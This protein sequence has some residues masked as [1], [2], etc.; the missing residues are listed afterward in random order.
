MTRFQ[1]TRRFLTTRV[2][3]GPNL[4]VRAIKGYNLTRRVTSR[5]LVGKFVKIKCVNPLT[6][7]V[8]KVAF[9]CLKRPEKTKIIK[10]EVEGSNR[11]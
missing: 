10:K 3:E 8:I 7:R 6:H 11:P 2:F 5:Q 1:M 4:R 9:I